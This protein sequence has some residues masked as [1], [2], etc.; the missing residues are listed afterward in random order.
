VA[1]TYGFGPKTKES[2]KMKKFDALMLEHGAELATIQKQRELEEL[3]F[4]EVS[5]TTENLTKSF[6]TK[7]R[8]LT[9]KK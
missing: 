5:L 3:H 4:G 6:I 7:I 9:E 8:D 2:F 1:K